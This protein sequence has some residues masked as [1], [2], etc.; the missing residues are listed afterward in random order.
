MNKSMKHAVNCTAMRRPWCLFGLDRGD[1]I[2]GHV[3]GGHV[4]GRRNSGK[5]LEE[6]SKLADM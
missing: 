3:V 4:V 6:R 5:A 2:G 1:V